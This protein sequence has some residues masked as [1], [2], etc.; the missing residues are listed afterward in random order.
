MPPGDQS[1]A[2]WSF[3]G[4]G[5]RCFYEV[6]IHGCRD[7]HVLS[8]TQSCTAPYEID[9]GLRNDLDTVMYSPLISRR[10]SSSSLCLSRVQVRSYLSFS[11][12]YWSS[13]PLS[14]CCVLHRLQLLSIFLL[15]HV[16]YSTSNLFPMIY[17]FVVLADK[18]KRKDGNCFAKCVCNCVNLSPLKAICSDITANKSTWHWKYSLLDIGNSEKNDEDYM[19]RCSTSNHP[20]VEVQITEVCIWFSLINFSSTY[21][22]QG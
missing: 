21:L 16:D 14:L 2:H 15:L 10:R 17:R 9:A 4:R 5:R 18:P 1:V 22:I 12:A 8:S 7:A 19:N 11:S 20:E 3:A 6:P 13:P